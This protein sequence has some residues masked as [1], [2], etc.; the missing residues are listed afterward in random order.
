[1]PE[2]IQ[3]QLIEKSMK[4]AYID[5]AMSVISQRALPN[6]YDGLKPVHRRILYTMNKLGLLH[7]KP[8]RKSAFIVGRVMGE[9]HPHGDLAIYD[10]LVRMAQEFSLRYPLVRGQG[11]FGSIDGDRQAAQ[12]YT[13]A[14]LAK[15]ASELLTDIEKETVDFQ[16]NYDG[17]IEEPI[18]LPAKLPNLLI[19]GSAGIAVGMA[20]NIPP[21]NVSEVI[22]ATIKLVNNPEIE[23]KELLESVQ[24]PDFPT[25][26]MIMG[27]SGILNAYKTGR[28]KVIVKAKTDIED[29]KII[30][31]EIPY[32]VNKGLLIE[33]I[34]D[35]VKDKYIE[36]IADILDESD[37][38]GMRIVIKL[39]KGADPQVT[40]NQLFTQTALKTTFGINMLAIHDGEPKIMNLRDILQHY[41]THRKEVVTR[42]TKFD[43]KKAEDRAHL[44]EGLK[45]ALENID[46]V[47]KSIKEAETVEVARNGLMNDY[48]LTQVQAQ[49]ILDMRLQKIT[50]LETSKIR[51]EHEELLKLIEELKGV[52]A[53]E[54]KILDIIKLELTELREGYG[55]TRRT[56]ILDQE[57]VT[58]QTE[59]LI[60]EEK[61][62]ITATYSGYI[63]KVPMK[64]YKQQKRGG[65]GV[66]GTETKEEDVVQNLFTT[67]NLNYL[68]FFTNKGKV[69]WLK[70]YDVPTG[71]RY[72]RGK[73][74]VNLL[75]LKE[76]EKVSSILP[77][78]KFDDQ[79]FITLVT[80]KGLIKKTNLNEFSHPRQGG[81]ISIGLKDNDEVVLGRLTSGDKEILIG[82]KE[83]VAIRFN[84]A[85][86]R[87]MGRTASGVRAIKLRSEDEVVGLEL[88]EDGASLLTITE[89]GF[90]KRTKI[91][92]Y[93]KIKR[94]GKGVIN[95][96]TTNRNGK[97][98]GIKM[99]DDSREVLF[100]SQK[101][102]IIRVQAKDI[103]TIGRNT[104]GLRIMKVSD[105]DKVTT[106]AKIIQEEKVEEE[107]DNI[108]SDQE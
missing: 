21:H 78:S 70:A 103:S 28:G 2:E 77:V 41:L 51:K 16:L 47:V 4:D 22:D 29:N 74:L 59:D 95:I 89:N 96:Q 24:G 9:L 5:Y 12:R 32:M 88:V 33:S 100:M 75:H 72:A 108:Q 37:R 73:A 49:A 27:R 17:S 56:Q 40:L 48:K 3:Q 92:E 20:T 8:F 85:D 101:G 67:S 26:G 35:K 13:E 30:I 39:K 19:N 46:P 53:S 93:S 69:H 94:G 80:K 65:K 81:I 66:I 107:N 10:A 106:V 87:P 7:N 76:G 14:K 57:D 90:G 44:L 99:V 11:N 63:K 38:D 60:E 42:R 82:T 34:A 102:V 52:L 58:I 43:L 91:E 62:V 18:V 54:Q 23:D 98:V 61:V 45:V 97:V 55:D 83:G 15:I 104:Q 105:S 68:L 6:V 31:T 79:H 50:S 71:S 64:T 86:V 84:E 36:N 25:G 1:M